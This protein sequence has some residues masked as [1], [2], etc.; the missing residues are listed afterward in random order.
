M[1]KL[2][3]LLAL[4]AVVFLRVY[5]GGEQESVPPPVV[6]A[7]PS[8]EAAFDAGYWVTRPSDGTLTIIGIAGRRANRVLAVDEARK[9]ALYHGLHAES[10]AVLNQGAGTLDYF[11]GF[12]YR[13]TPANGHEGYIDALDYDEDADIFEKNGVVMAR[14]R[15]AVAAAVPSCAVAVKDGVPDWTKRF[16][17]DIP[18]FLSGVGH[19]A[20]K[21]SL[22][23]TSRASYEAAVVSL[24]PRLSMREENEVVDVAGAQVTRN[25]ARSKV[26]LTGI[27][28]LEA[29]LDRR[30]GAVW[31]LVVAKAAC[32]DSGDK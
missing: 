18:G 17:A 4:W 31:T 32:G 15:Y 8:L 30:T 1:K 24:L 10:A 9:A 20:N 26:N 12:D 3:S 5:P 6:Q 11:S 13:I 7:E 27:V 21:G 28:I 14:A 23:R 29:W 25:I 19:A 2:L 16:M 22:Q